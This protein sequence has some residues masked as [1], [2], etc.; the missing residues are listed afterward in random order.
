MVA[1]SMPLKLNSEI[2]LPKIIG[3]DQIQLPYSVSALPPSNF[4]LQVGSAL[5]GP[6]TIYVE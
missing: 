3:F 1:S 4:Y 6:F 2:L 5:R